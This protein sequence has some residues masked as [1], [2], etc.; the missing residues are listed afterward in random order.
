MTVGLRLQGLHKRY[1]GLTVANAIDLTL[2]PGARCALIGPNGAGKTTIANLITGITQPSA[3]RILLGDRDL[4]GV[5]E[6]ARVKAG[7]AKTFQITNLFAGMSVRE[8]LRLAI[9]ERCGRT[10]RLGSRADGDARIE[11]EIDERLTALGLLGVRD[12]EVA[13]L[14]YGQQRLVELALTLALQPRILILDEPAAGVPADESHLIQDAIA[15]LPADLSV[16]IIEHDMRLVFRVATEIVVLVNGSI[17]MRGTPAEVAAD[18]RVRELYLGTS[19]GVTGDA[20]RERPAAAAETATGMPAGAAA[21]EAAA[22]TQGASS[23]A[24]S[25]TVVDAVIA[26]D[27]PATQPA[28]A[29]AILA[30]ARVCAGYGRTQVLD[31]ISLSLKAGERLA[32]VGRNGVGKTTLLATIMGLTR[33]HSGTIH[34]RGTAIHHLATHRRAALGVGLVPQTRDIFA[35]LSVE[36]NL[37]AARRGDTSLDDAWSLFPRL[38]E[39]RGNMG[40]QLS[41]GEQQMLAIARTLMAGPQ[42]LLLDEPLEGLAPVICEMLMRVFERLARE[43]GHTIVLVEQH[44]SLALGFAERAIVLDHGE[45]VHTGPAARLASDP[46]ALNR[47]LGVG[48]EPDPALT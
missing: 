23:A 29:D 38:H 27:P 6:A 14:A 24:A 31:S 45:I 7:I 13:V 44:A 34:L 15:A 48:L 18:A 47:L 10:A 22:A 25:A 21:A 17:L 19:S 35:S 12:V 28:Q 8:N 11:A 1:G 26:A 4:A 46:A 41:G 32:I 20:T 33:L 37:L 30:L 36:E 2:A 42:I 5:G 43:R 39:R 3:G 16:L 40:T 9:L